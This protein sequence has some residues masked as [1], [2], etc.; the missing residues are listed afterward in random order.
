MSVD[1]SDIVNY[2]TIA[3]WLIA[4]LL[5]VGR[6]AKGKEK[7]PD[8]LSRV[9]ASNAVLAVIIAL[10]LIG[11]AAQAY[12]NFYSPKVV[13]RI[14]EKTVPQDCPQVPSSS[15]QKPAKAASTAISPTHSTPTQT[16]SGQGNTQVGSVNQGPGSALS[17]NQQ[18]GV[19]AAYNFG[20]VHPDPHFDWKEIELE[21]KDDREANPP[22]TEI[23]I[24]LDGIM[25][26]VAFGAICNR[27][28]KGI[29]FLVL[30]TGMSMPNDLSVKSPP[31]AVAYF[32]T[33][34]N[35]VLPG[36]KLIMRIQSMDEQKVKIT[37]VVRIDPK[38]IGAG[39]TP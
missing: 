26:N 37:N 24:T 15:D 30:A 6:L 12:L 20:D 35:P 32:L 29:G 2:G 8:G 1:I 5:Y 21:S 4:A 14:V 22:I 7:L 18:G 34:P 25:Y 38:E 27:P 23:A 3:Q 10:G 11:S 33:T 17:F 39:K 28:C 16:Q 19:T 9:L 36:S 13:E 31:N